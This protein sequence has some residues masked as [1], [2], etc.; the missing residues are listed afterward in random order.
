MAKSLRSGIWR[1]GLAT[2]SSC[3]KVLHHW[4]Y[5]LETRAFAAF[6]I[7]QRRLKEAVKVG[8]TSPG[9]ALVK[10]I[11]KIEG[12]GSGTRT[13]RDGDFVFLIGAFS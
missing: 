10:K 6:D 1:E 5:D 13:E 12:D 2:R 3:S 8:S 9:N 7:V 4:L 11:S